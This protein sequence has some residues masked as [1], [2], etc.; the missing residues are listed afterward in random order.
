MQTSTTQIPFVGMRLLLA[1]VT[2]QL[3]PFCPHSTSKAAANHLN[4]QLAVSLGPKKITVN[5]ILP[6][7]FPS[8]VSS[9]LAWNT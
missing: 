1:T 5:A 9:L 2:D 8:K 6:G 7:V 4:N 3:F